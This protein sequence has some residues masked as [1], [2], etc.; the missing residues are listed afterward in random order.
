MNQH[1]QVPQGRRVRGRARQ[2]KADKAKEWCTAAHMKEMDAQV[3]KIT[4]SKKRKSAQEHLDES[5]AAFKKNDT[6]GCVNHMEL[7][8]KVMGL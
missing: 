3:D 8:H 1:L 7:A 4:D 2:G 5:K 6:A